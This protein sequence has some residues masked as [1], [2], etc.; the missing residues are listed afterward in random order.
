MV[1]K[2]CRYHQDEHF[3]YKIRFSNKHTHAQTHTYHRH[4]QTPLLPPTLYLVVPANDHAAH[5]EAHA[6]V[7]QHH[8]T[9]QL[10]G[11]RH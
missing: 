11:C 9:Q 6:S 3:G 10:R 2:K 4:T 8:V 7:S 5:G 1:L